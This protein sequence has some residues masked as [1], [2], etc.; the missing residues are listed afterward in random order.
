MYN[1]RFEF[2]Q[3]VHMASVIFNEHN[4]PLRLSL[5]DVDSSNK[6][7][8]CNYAGASKAGEIK[9]TANN[10]GTNEPIP[11]SYFDSCARFEEFISCQALL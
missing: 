1:V 8:S 11:L 2:V 6:M 5:C 3:F 9:N 10:V 7:T 4:F